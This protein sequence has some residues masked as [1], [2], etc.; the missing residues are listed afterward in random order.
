VVIKEALNL[1][2]IEAGVGRFPVG[3]MSAEQREKLKKVLKDM[4]AI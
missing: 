3:G 2:G 4:G 1:M